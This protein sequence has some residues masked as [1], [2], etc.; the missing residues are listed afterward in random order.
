MTFVREARAGLQSGL[1]ASIQAL[2]H[3]MI[4]FATIGATGATYGMSAAL[5]VSGAAAFAMA[6]I[7]RSRPL[8]A[9]TTAAAAI[10]VGAVIASARPENLD[11]AIALAMALV[12][13]AGLLVVILA[14]SG[15]ARL[16]AML[17]AAVSQGLRNATAAIVTLT[18]LP[19][20]MGGTPGNGWPTPTPGSMVTAAAALILM[21]R[22]VSGM[23]ASVLALAAATA[24][25]HALAAAGVTVGPEIGNLLAPAELVSA[26]GGGWHALRAAPPPAELVLAGAATIA[27][28]A[29]AETL[30]A[31]A[32]LREATGKRTQFSRDLLGAGAGLIAGASLGGMPASALTVPTMTSWLAGGRTRTAQL[33]GAIVPP[34]LLLLG[35]PLLGELPLSGLAAVLAGAVARL[36]ELPPSPWSTGP[37]RTRRLLDAAISCSVLGAALLSGLLAAVG[38]GVL[39]AVTIFTGSM[40]RAPIR[41]SYRNPI[42]RSQV[43][44]RVET[45]VRLRAEGDAIALL[46]LEGPIF[47][48]SADHV[49]HQVEREFAAA[50]KVVVLDMSRITHID[51]SGGRRLLEACAIAPGRVL[52]APMHAS[53]RAA[54]EF[55]ALGL[56]RDLPALALCFDLASAVER[57]ESIV[58]QGSVEP[59]T[60]A[61]AEDPSRALA[62]L[63]LPPGCIGP[64][65]DLTTRVSF[66][67]GDA[68]LKAGDASD[69]AYL[70]LAG[71][72]LISIGGEDGK[73]AARLAVLAPGVLF[74]EAALLGQVRRTADATARGAVVCLRIDGE[75]AALLR[76]R[77]PEIAWHL[78]ATVARQLATHLRTANM[79]IA[80]LEA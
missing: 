35:E 8:V 7:G 17:P 39:V 30:S 38:V 46:E 41:R 15:L 42:G 23:P 43:R 34:V 66:A 50:A 32:T 21:L 13:V 20:L 31:S 1:V 9:T 57:A 71:E 56:T 10:I 25:H 36:V 79:T 63:G 24:T 55:D 28:L 2:N 29:S 65:L 75:K 5:L 70:L 69:A 76:E 18:V 16:T 49:L 37:G 27:L 67:D 26:I 6:L 3:G 64:I 68:I 33:C 12:A 51:M 62:A 72:V 44:R 74:G 60:V 54:E 53:S 78:T 14:A 48:G 19:L 11:E 61:P 52:L 45:E 22:P 59:G 47:F 4:A 40:A 77:S 73:P 58:L 80:K